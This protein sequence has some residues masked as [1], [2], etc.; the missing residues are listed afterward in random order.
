MEFYFSDSNL[1]RDNFLRDKVEENPDGF[2][3]VALL[4]I[5]ARMQQLLKNSHKE[6]SKVPDELIEAVAEALE[7]SEELVLSDNKRRVRRAHALDAP[8]EEVAQAVDERSLYASPFPFDT[9]LDTLVGEHRAA[10]DQCAC[11]GGRPDSPAAGVS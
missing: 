3:D 10:A 6:V 4:C 11:E 5:F 9:S 7:P 1:P 2:V 8:A